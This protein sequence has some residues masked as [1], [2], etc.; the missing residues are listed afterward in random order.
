VE[1]SLFY[2]DS[3]SVNTFQGVTRIYLSL[4]YVPDWK[5]PNSITFWRST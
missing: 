3:V 4:R 2:R 1:K 5:P